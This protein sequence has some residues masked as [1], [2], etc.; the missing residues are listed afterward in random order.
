MRITEARLRR[1]IREMLDQTASGSFEAEYPLDQIIHRP[2]FEDP[3][4]AWPVVINWMKANPGLT[5]AQGVY[6]YYRYDQA[7]ATSMDRAL[8]R[9]DRSLAGIFD[10]KIEAAESSA[11]THQPAV[12]SRMRMI[13]ALRGINDAISQIEE[14]VGVGKFMEAVTALLPAPRAKFLTLRVKEVEAARSRALDELRM[15]LGLT[16]PPPPPASKPSRGRELADEETVAEELR[17]YIKNSHSPSEPTRAAIQRYLR[18][19]MNDEATT[20]FRS[21]FREPS[22]DEDPY[23]YRGISVPEDD[24]PRFG[25]NPAG[26]PRGVWV[27]LGPDESGNDGDMPNR[28]TPIPREIKIPN[29]P[30]VTVSS[31]TYSPLEAR[32]FASQGSGGAARLVLAADMFGG[33][34]EAKFLEMYGLYEELDLERFSDEVELLGVASEANPIRGRVMYVRLP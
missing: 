29:L 14:H 27:L 18:Q 1:L 7:R 4:K 15:E 8:A 3:N 24:L 21:L 32:K 23:A 20:S 28:E 22:S 25:V 10:R 30:G 26:L 34:N 31:W 19:S 9:I 6:E 5:I 2:A 13:E 17:A 11:S 16:A 33:K 12:A